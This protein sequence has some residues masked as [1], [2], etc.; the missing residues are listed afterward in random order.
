MTNDIVDA[1]VSQSPL[2]YL[3]TNIA[4]I[5]F[6]EVASQI[7]SILISCGRLSAKE[8]SF[9]LKT[10]L[11]DIKKGLVSLIQF[12]CI[13]YWEEKNIFYYLNESGLVVLSRCGIIVEQIKHE[14]GENEANIVLHVLQNGHIKAGDLQEK[15]QQIILSKLYE[16]GWLKRLQ[17]FNYFPL[18][19]LWHKIYEG[20][21][22][23][24]PRS[25]TVSEIKRVTEAKERAK[26]QLTELLEAGT[27]DTDIFTVEN[28][29]RQLKPT[30]TIAFNLSR[31]EKHIR[32]RELVN[33]CRSRIGTLTSLIYEN[34]LKLIEKNSP[35]SRHPFKDLDGLINDP[36][37]ERVFLNSIE[38]QLVDD[39]KTVFTIKQLTK[40]IPDGLDLTNS[41]LTNTFSKPFP[42]KRPIN[43]EEGPSAKKVK[44]EGEIPEIDFG[45]HTA[46]S[47]NING[48]G[49]ESAK[50]RLVEE[51]LKLLTSASELK[52]LI[53]ISPGRYTVPYKVLSEKLKKFNYETLIKRTLGADAFRILRC[54][55]S[56]KLVDERTL[57]NG[58]LLREKN[59]RSELYKLLVLDVVEIQEVPRSAD[60]A[61]SKA[62]YLYRHKEAPSYKFLRES[63]L[64]S[65]A[66][67]LTNIR[68]LKEDH[69]ILLQKCE[70]EDVKGNEEELLIESE[71][72]TLKQLRQREV[73]D[74]G[75]FNRIDILYSLFNLP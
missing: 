52:F 71:L 58:T 24:M 12:N 49:I 18:G 68:N 64:F 46:N 72:K 63:L 6:G 57:A 23:D 20:V 11:R 16:D 59:V 62:F 50:Q 38:N 29:Y 75:K 34:A 51:H 19:D 43:T 53:E 8:I 70:R 25:S 14:Y 42:K 66:E 33:L 56:M 60:R 28:G 73:N 1:A 40:H 44:L 54:L 27:K 10:P 47:V 22:K 32:S 41:I 3:L 37:Q 61:A 5:H 17:K 48:N 13:T 45:H 36:E 4:R 35:D 31:F 65:M 26:V 9:K 21:L 2:S 39:G 55:K 30:I 7:I 69:K 74:I 67:I 15:S